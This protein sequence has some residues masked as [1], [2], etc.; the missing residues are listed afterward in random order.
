MEPGRELDALI[1]EK[2]FRIF[3]PEGDI[4]QKQLGPFPQ[5]D[6]T[7]EWGINTRVRD[8]G[9]LWYYRG[10]KYST[11]IGPAWEVVEK[12]R[13]MDHGWRKYD[14]TIQQ[15]D[16]LEGG[17]WCVKTEAPPRGHGN[18]SEVWVA[19]ETAPYAICL[20]ALKAVKP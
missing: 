1:A 4:G 12:I 2:V 18:F 13:Q 9:R 15:M 6:E 20:A 8:G 17:K 14:F 10:P 11:E 16:R 19:A 7:Y 3:V 5:G